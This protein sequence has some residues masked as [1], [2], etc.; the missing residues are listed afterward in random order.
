MKGKPVLSWAL[1]LI[2]LFVTAIRCSD[3][4]KT[5]VPTQNIVAL[6][7][8]NTNLS[9]LVAALSKFPDLVSTLSGSGNFTVFAPTNQAFTALLA[10]RGQTDINNVPDDVLKSIL[11]Y[12]VVTSGAV[13]STQLTAGNVNTAANENIAVT[14]NP[15]KLNTNTN[16]TAADVLASNGVVHI[17]DQVLVDPSILPIVGTIYAPAYFNKDFSTLVAAVKG[18]S[19]STRD[20]LL[21]STNIVS[22]NNPLTIRLYTHNGSIVVVN[23]LQEKEFKEES[24]QRGLQNIQSR[25]RLLSDEKVVIEKLAQ[26]FRVTIPLLQLQ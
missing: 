23:N 20:L 10:A 4:K 18:A 19:Q 6:A 9:S 25:Y 2:V 11:Q 3:D 24:T 17:I 8:A 15:I 7:S 26:E 1:A 5:P 13:R 14:I 22:K 12:H 21:N 16:V